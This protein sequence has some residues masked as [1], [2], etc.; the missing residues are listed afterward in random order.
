VLRVGDRFV[1]HFDLTADLVSGFVA[2]FGDR[3][4]L[5]TDP[6]YARARGFE[7]VV[8][9]GNVLS[10]FLSF[11]VGECYPEPEAIILSQ[12]I[13]F[14]RPV[15]V[16]DHLSLEAE[17]VGIHDS[18]NVVDMKYCF[19]NQNGARVASA[20]MQ[21]GHTSQNDPVV[22]DSNAANKS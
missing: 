15:Y 3:H 7:G 9:H 19:I 8:V 17:V 11:F 14:S 6:A 12:A 10:G 5:H 18:V 20:K 13:K 2:L 1:E 21:V 16:G 4:P 22:G